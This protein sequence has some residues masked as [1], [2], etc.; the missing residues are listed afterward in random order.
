MAGLAQINIKFTADLRGFSTEMQ[1][2]M[3]RIGAMGN[4]MKALG[5]QMSTYVTLPIVAAAAAAVKFAS[6]YN[7]SLNKVDVSFKD[8]SASVKEFAKTSLESF[9][10]SEGTALDM[11][12]T[13][14]DMSTSMGLSTSQAAKMSTELVALAGDLASFKNISIDV[15][16]T[17][18]TAVYS[19]ETESLK[20]LGIVITEVNLKHFAAASGVKKVYEQMSQAEKVQLRYNYILSVTKNSQG[21][22]IR[23]QGGAANQMR[24]FQESLKQVA[25]QL[26]SI[27]LPFFTK[28]ITSV[29]SI[30]KGFGNLSEGSKVLIVTIAA[31]SAVVGPLLSVFG[32]ILTFVPNLI[33]KFNALKDALIGMQAVLLAN[34]FTAL[35]VG[36]AALATIVLVS[37][38]RF[39]ALTN[40][41]R[42]FANI[43]NVATDSLV[44][45]KTEL[46]KHLAIAKNKAI[47][48]DIRKKSIQEINALS[49]QFLGNITLENLYTK[50]TTE[51]VKKYTSAMLQKAKVQ[52]AEDKLVET[53][54][55]LLEL[56]LGNL[57]AVKP[58]VWQNLGNSFKAAGNGAVFA[59]LSAKT[60]G[61]NLGIEFVEA[62][63]LI[64]KLTDF[65]GKNQETAASNDEVADSITNVAVA[66]EKVLKSGTIAFYEKQIEGLQK[67]QTETATTTVEF[68]KYG[69]AIDA[70][71]LKID[72]IQKKGIKLP[73]PE[74]SQEVDFQPQSLNIPYYEEQIARYKQLQS[75]FS[76]NNEEGRAKFQM[77]ADKINNTE[78]IIQD[79]QGVDTFIESSNV[80]K[81]TML[82]LTA[83]V[84]SAVEQLA[85]NAASGIGEAIGG[86]VSGTMTMGDVFKSML[87]VIAGFMKS[88]GESL[89][90]AGL[91][92]IAFK[93][94]LANPVAAVVVGVALVAL[95]SIVQAKL[96]AGPKTGRYQEGGITGG[97]S[98]YGDKILARVNSGE[99]I[100]NSNQQRKIWGAMNSGGDGGF[101]SSTKIQGSDL[102]VVIERAAARKNRIG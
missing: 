78:L 7:E 86:L 88:L 67:L 50:Q 11:A 52:A 89:I 65:I 66:F 19:G 76:T 57:E 75:E 73:K 59:A 26:G 63:K 79:I 15:A 83:T 62:Q 22:F 98:Y 18:L 51:A 3:R 97:S 12:S 56:Q 43:N 48:D 4:Q 9:G 69:N 24:I 33:T 35:A 5:N 10:I 55:K 30:I 36:I 27:I 39:S 13:F 102:L 2:S 80:L 93:K 1:N 8:S 45:Q 61:Q 87:G 92:G 94:L 49:P 54:K 25:Q 68:N 72:A 14:G 32:S 58:S 101:V 74:V 29:N 71:Q 21:D 60:L 17:A 90:A 77:Y 41:E 47:S 85:E 84:N 53:Q 91:A 44:K 100:A 81:S 23:T 95:S 40:A 96:Q 42:D 37:S 31:I 64:N 16:N 70:I 20:K 99:L 82:D 38:S 28:L 46:E 6:D 34:P